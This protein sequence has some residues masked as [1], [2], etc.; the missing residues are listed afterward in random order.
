M[1]EVGVQG[2]SWYPHEFE[3]KLAT[4]SLNKQTMAEGKASCN[5]PLRHQKCDRWEV[6]STSSLLSSSSMSP[7]YHPIQTLVQIHSTRASP[8]LHTRLLHF[9]WP[10]PK[11]AHFLSLTVPHKHSL[12]SPRTAKV[13]HEKS[14]SQ[15]VLRMVCAPK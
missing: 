2:N 4:L 12:F 13:L 7:T 5:A 15:T 10:G 1:Q 14:V 3:A 11:S 6:L 8:Y 9:E